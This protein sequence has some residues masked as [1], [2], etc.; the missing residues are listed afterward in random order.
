MTG[1][2]GLSRLE[3]YWRLKIAAYEL[4]RLQTLR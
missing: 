1:L 2:E 4:G 3:G